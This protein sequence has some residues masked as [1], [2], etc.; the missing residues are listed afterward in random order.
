MTEVTA[1]WYVDDD[2]SFS[3]SVEMDL[4]WGWYRGAPGTCVKPIVVRCLTKLFG[5][6]TWYGT[7]PFWKL[8]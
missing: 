3:T 5:E 4:K 1:A 7:V 8:G 2:N 6:A